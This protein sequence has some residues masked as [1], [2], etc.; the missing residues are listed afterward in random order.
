MQPKRL[1]IVERTRLQRG[2]AYT[3]MAFCA[4]A[5]AALMLVIAD[6]SRIYFIAIALNSAARAGA[7]YGIQ[8]LTTA[9]DVTGMQTA[10]ANDDLNLSMSPVASQFCECSVGGSTVSCTNPGCSNPLVYC[11]V[12]TSATFTP[13][14]KWPGIN[15][16]VALSGKAVMRAQ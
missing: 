8:N 6:Y 10:A 5:I 12:T 13:F 16:S 11:Q 14:W 9:A 15:G 1:T 4:V 7:Q 3:E 2:Q